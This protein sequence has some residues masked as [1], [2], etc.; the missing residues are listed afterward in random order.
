MQRCITFVIAVLLVSSCQT[1]DLTQYQS[2]FIPI[3]YA[4]SDR[5]EGTYSNSTSDSIHI[6]HLSSYYSELKDVDKDS[7]SV[8]LKVLD[9]KN[10]EC[11]LMYNGVAYDQILMR[12]KF[13]DGLFTTR[14][15]KSKMVV[16]PL[17]WY[18]G[19][20]KYYFGI[21][22]NN[23]LCLIHSDG[24][25]MLMLIAFPIMVAGGHEGAK[26]F[27]RISN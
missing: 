14:K 25:G 27:N 12:G 15:W 7:L 17:V 19:A 2:K 26:E 13:K 6:G 10:I 22:V 21:N 3:T 9:K 5:L 4:E 23:N 1:L 20:Q 16:G 24:Y 8:V 18:L 11:S